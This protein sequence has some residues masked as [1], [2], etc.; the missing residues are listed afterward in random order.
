MIFVQPHL[1]S[2]IQVFMIYNEL[3][4]VDLVEDLE[5]LFDRPTAQTI[6]M[7]TLQTVPE[8]TVIN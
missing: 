3:I 4:S 7:Q 8:G 6:H 5:T 2:A 1:E